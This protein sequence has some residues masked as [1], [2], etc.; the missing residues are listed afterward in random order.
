MNVLVPLSP[1]VQYTVQSDNV[2]AVFSPETAAHLNTAF[3]ELNK[4][5]IVPQIN[6]GFRTWG[7]QD[8]MRG[9]TSGSN[10]AAMFSW[11]GGPLKS[12]SDL[13]RAG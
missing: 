13:R 3:G 8:R 5:G 6:S 11:A 7:D 2:H 1:F 10:P 4:D 9:G 12:R